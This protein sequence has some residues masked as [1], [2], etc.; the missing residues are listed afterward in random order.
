MTGRTHDMAAV[1]F[2]SAVL[3]TQTIPSINFQTLGVGVIATLIG[4]LAPD[5]DQATGALWNR[6]PA[7]YYMGKIFNWVLIGG[8]R[9]ISHSIIGLFLF[10]WLFDF[11]LNP[12]VGP[13]NLQHEVIL[14][15]FTIAYFS[16]LIM[17][18]LTTEGV[19]WLWPIPFK[20]GF[21]PLSR[22]RIKTGGVFENF[23]VEPVLVA[24]TILLYWHYA[25]VVFHLLKSL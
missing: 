10:R 17:D 13:Y 11:L 6:L 23:I 3:L 16:H 14:W 19:P 15:A 21:P 1:T 9:A 22:L 7:G 25:P 24:L 4:G 8:H 12:L 5:L 20:F 2:V 18:S